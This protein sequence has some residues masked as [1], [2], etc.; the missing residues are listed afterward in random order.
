MILHL[1]ISVLWI[2]IEHSLT[3]I[4]LK[5]NLDSNFVNSDIFCAFGALGHSLYVRIK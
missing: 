5:E 3:L 1:K 2:D 4:A